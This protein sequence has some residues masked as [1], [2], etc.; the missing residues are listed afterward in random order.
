MQGRIG[1]F[2]LRGGGRKESLHLLRQPIFSS[3]S[4]AARQRARSDPGGMTGPDSPP[5][6]TG[7]V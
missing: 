4:A 2:L 7:S 5:A 6:E 1:A 3:I